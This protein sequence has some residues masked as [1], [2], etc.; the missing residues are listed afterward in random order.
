MKKTTTC[1]SAIIFF[2]FL[3]LLTI[4]CN[5]VSASPPRTT[6]HIKVDQFGYFPFSK[7]VAVIADPQTGQN[8][9]EQFTPGTGSN[10]YQVRRWHDDSVVFSGTLQVWNAGATHAQSGDKGW[11][12]DF[13]TVT[14]PGS[15][16]VF[17]VVNNIG[18]FQFQISDQVYDGVLRQAMRTFFYQRIN[19][20]KQSPYVDTKWA[21]G[22]CF[23]GANQDR[24]ATSRFA[25]GDMTTA[26][27]VSGGWMD[28][29]D[30]NKYTTFALSPIVQLMEAYRLNPKVFKDDYGIPESGNGLPDILDEVKWELDFL[31]RMQ[32]ATGTNGFL[33]KVGLDNNEEVYPPSADKRARYYLPECTSSS[34]AGCAAFAV[35]GIVLKGVPALSA[36][37]GDLLTRAQKAWERAKLTTNNFTTFQVECD[38]RNIKSGDA[39]HKADQQLDNAVVA[40]IYLYEATGN[41]EYRLFAESNYTKVHLYANKWWGPYGMPQQLALLRLTTLPGVSSEVVTNIRS[42]KGNMDYQNS[43]NSYTAATDLYRSQMDDAAFHWG[44]NQVRANAGNTN[45]DYVTFNI[46]TDRAKLYKEV[47]EQ[48]L[49]WMHGVNPLGLVMLSNMYQHGAEKCVN[50]I[51]HTWFKDGTSWDNALTSTYGPP[52][53]YVTGGPNSRYS[54]PVTGITNQPP[55]KAYKDWNTDW[56]EYS[57]EVTEPAIYYQASYISLLSRLMYESTSSSTGKDSVA[58]SAPQ[59]LLAEN[60]SQNTLTVRWNAASDNVGITEYNVYRDSVRIASNIIDTF[61]HVS[62]LACGTGYKFSVEARDAAGNVSAM[63]SAL[64]AQTL[65]CTSSVARVVYD[66]ALNTGWMDM[67]VA[68]T[69]TYNTTGTVKTGSYS[70]KA[71]YA[72]QGM[73]TFESETEAAVSSNSQLRFWVYNTGKADLKVYT[74]NNSGIKSTD[75]MLEPSRNK[76]QEVIISMSQ[77]GDPASIE[78]I[79]FQNTSSSAATFYFD[80]IQLTNVSTSTRVAAQVK[81]PTGTGEPTPLW[82]VYPNPSK[83]V[84]SLHV[85][86]TGNSMALVRIIDNTGRTVFRKNT[87]VAEGFN[88]L[89]F[90]VLHLKQGYYFLQYEAGKVKMVEKILITN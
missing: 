68:C 71:A 26:R 9:D 12:F 19:F 30:K 77:L 4:K 14:A 47:A 67:S 23:E 38:D 83:G 85:S 70:L 87:P 81:L 18:S 90:S 66:D 1:F 37:G 5:D 57:W 60:I 59:N 53:G 44:H 17:D 54:G 79:T 76:W 45:L 89:P 73:L 6:Y 28:A 64:L 21:D 78:S 48:Y 42:M 33:L 75:V 41:P 10:Q 13:T 84:F 63:S 11:W 58:P 46:N 7:K 72:P 50:E 74:K 55:Q 20:A 51:F 35:S 80:Q 61:M 82:R 3:A 43:I 36:Y 29:G 16:Y 69:R 56:P 15:Y 27:D 62:A 25:K 86:A 24:Y 65:S 32:D 22:A 52:P 31:K 39:D 2:C 8:A 88:M 34:I 49:H 40:A